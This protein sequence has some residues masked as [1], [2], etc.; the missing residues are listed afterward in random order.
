MILIQAS[1]KRNL[2]IY[3]VH[4]RKNFACEKSAYSEGIRKKSAK[5]SS[6]RAVWRTSAVENKILPR[7]GLCPQR[8]KRIDADMGLQI[9]FSKAD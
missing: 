6:I 9:A 7:I 3:Q 2:G 4:C 5:V 1:E 8:I